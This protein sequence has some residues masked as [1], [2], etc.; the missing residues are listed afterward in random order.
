[1]S[2]GI[3]QRDG[4]FAVRKA[5]WWDLTG[6]H[7]LSD[8]P[9]REEAQKIAHNWEPVEEPI[10]R[11]VE[12]IVFDG[13]GQEV[14]VSDYEEVEGFKLNARSDD[15]HPLGVVSDTFVTV[16][17]NE[18]Y[19]I[20]EAI[21][22][23][24]KGAVK[25]ETGGSLK[26]GA[27]VWLLLCLR[28]PLMVNGDPHGATIP[29][30][31]MQDSKD[32]SGAF[33]GQATM[34]RIVCDNTS[35][36][37][38]L[39][40]QARGTEMLFRHTKNIQERIDQAR[41]AMAGWRDSV[42]RYRLLSEDLIQTRVSRDQVELF[43]CEFIPMPEIHAVSDRVVHNVE[44]ARKALRD[45]LASQTCEGIDRSAYGLVQASVEYLEHARA[46]RSPESRFKRAY[47]ER[48]TIVTDA[49]QL[50]RQVVH[51]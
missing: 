35:H 51:A 44:T 47:L 18:M 8:Y 36:M 50:A 10:Y 42:Q 6:A 30:F 37:A 14:P 43:V 22:G 23:Q 28:E 4:M 32:G 3:T 20:A 48:N 11:R 12:H 7:V 46:A 15:G 19:D 17:N 34:T 45:I 33:R 38:D 1:M 31:A 21:E 41:E 27:K 24:D 40:A 49:V 25:F 13:I 26:G 9:T 29:Y 5:A 2:S 16:L 39:D